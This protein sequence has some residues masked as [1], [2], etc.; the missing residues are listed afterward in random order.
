MVGF[1]RERWPGAI[2]HQGSRPHGQ[3]PRCAPT[4]PPKM[5]SWK[6]HPR[7]NGC[8]G[9]TATT[10]NV[11]IPCAPWINT[12]SISAVA[13]GPV[14]NTPYPTSNWARSRYAWWRFPSNGSSLRCVFKLRLHL[15]RRPGSPDVYG[16]LV[17]TRATHGE[18]ISV[19]SCVCNGYRLQGLLRAAH[20]RLDFGLSATGSDRPLG[21]RSEQT[22]RSPPR[23][24]ARRLSLE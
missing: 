15:I 8:E 20:R 14:M 7:D 17:R 18:I 1:Y 21:A 19:A 24:A 2:A 13:D 12:P 5:F 9:A 10:V 4:R 16:N 3:P 6:D 23:D 22:R 11:R